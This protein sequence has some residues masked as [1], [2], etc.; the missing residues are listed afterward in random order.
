LKFSAQQIGLILKQFSIERLIAKE[1]L[2]DILK[3]IAPVSLCGGAGVLCQR[4]AGKKVRAT[5]E[6]LNGE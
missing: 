5:W 6:G 2:S 4:S 3:V 1:E